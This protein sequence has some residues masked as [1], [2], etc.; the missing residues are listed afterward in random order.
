[1]TTTDKIA[2]VREN[3]DLPLPKLAEAM[4][5]TNGKAAFVKMLIAV[6]DNPSLRLEAKTPTGIIGKTVTARKKADA[7]SSWGWLSARTGISEP[8]LKK[9]CEGRYEVFGSRIATERA[10]KKAKRSK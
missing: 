2:F 6:E 4:K 3:A 8:K 9:M 10:A 7:Y 1:M 5:C